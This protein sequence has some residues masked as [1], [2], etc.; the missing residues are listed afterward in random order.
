MLG[1][2]SMLP[3]NLSRREFLTALAI[4]GSSTLEGCSAEQLPGPP[5]V[6]EGDGKPR[7]GGTLR[8][9]VGEDVKTLDPIR[10]ID[11]VSLIGCQLIF[12]TL[13][14]FAAADSANPTALQPSLASAWSVSSDGKTLQFEIRE[15]A[16]FSNGEPVLAEDFVFGFERLL[17]P[18]NLAPAAQFFRVIEGAIDRLERRTTTV[19]GVRALGP[20]TL[21]IRLAK[22]DPSF[23]LLLALVA[24]TPQKKK[25]VEQ[26]GANIAEKPLG[27]GPFVLQSF[28]VGQELVLARNPFYWNADRP[29]LDSIRLRQSMPRETMLVEF[30]KGNLDI[31]DGRICNDAILLAHDERWSRYTER[32]PLPIITTDL[33]NTQRKPF[34]DKRV[35]QAFNYAINRNDSVK[36]T[37]GRGIAANGYLPPSVPGHNALRPIWPYDPARA[38][39]LLVEAGLGNGFEVTY[40][41]VRDE[42]AQKIAMSMQDDLAAIGVRMKIET[43]TFGAYINAIANGD[44]EFAFSGW[45]MDFPDPWNFLEVK[46]HGRMVAAG[47]NDSRYMNPEVDR[48]LDTARYELDP[49]KRLSLYGQAENIIVDDCPHIWHY[50]PSAL[51]VRHPRVRGPIRHPARDLFFRDTYVL[52]AS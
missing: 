33:M 27:T 50:F 22:A 5:K 48:L 28:Q 37:N 10:A 31:L 51:D 1:W 3:L 38:K 13:L 32:A 29:H 15:N 46:F 44:L 2:K 49:Q 25:Y 39:A 12:G 34:N 23:P 19:S 9:A 24:S 18:E 6:I 41:T 21:E 20:K 16:K 52:D 4:A 40:A 11:Q 14:E 26:I 17:S 45:S 8:C 7:R 47:T 36:L 35:R 42:M 43:V 30:L